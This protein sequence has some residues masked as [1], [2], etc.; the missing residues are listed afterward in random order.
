MIDQSNQA[1][2]DSSSDWLVIEWEWTW[3]AKKEKKKKSE[4]L[5]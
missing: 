1:D 5:N 4:K 2:L 3:Q